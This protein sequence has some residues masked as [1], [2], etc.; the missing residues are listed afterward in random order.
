MICKVDNDQLLADLVQGLSN[1]ASNSDQEYLQLACSSELVMK[2]MFELLSA[3]KEDKIQCSILKFIGCVM[4]I[5]N[6]AI[7]NKCLEFSALDRVGNVLN[8]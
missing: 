8:S 5:E 3:N 7:I 6:L 4:S 2:T 1:I